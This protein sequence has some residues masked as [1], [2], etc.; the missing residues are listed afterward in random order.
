MTVS[1]LYSHLSEKIPSSLSCEWDNDGLMCCPRADREVRRVLLT[2]DITDG[3]IACAKERGCDVII[4][5]HPLIFK[6]LPSIDGADSVSEAVIEL[7][8]S[9]I[10][11]FSFHTRLDA[12]SGGVNDV[13]AKRLGLCGCEPFGEEGIG[14]I[15]ELSSSKSTEEFALF[16]KEALGAPYVNY[17]DAGKTVHRVALL[18]GAGKDDIGAA[19]AAGADSYLSGE[20]G[21]HALQDAPQ[22]EMNL[23][24]AGHYFTEAPVL[25]VLEE[26]V[27]GADRSIQVE[28]FDSYRIKTV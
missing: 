25:C 23:F 26:L 15:G 20:L 3:A 21:Y 27:L 14:R 6:P 16:V 10:A 17:A 7:I 12:L 9:D 28:H 19:R 8:R 24:E 13:L 22:G 4:S 5:H 11:A 2:L 18:G 1:E